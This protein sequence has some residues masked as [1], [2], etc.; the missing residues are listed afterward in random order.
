M[1]L[2]IKN[3]NNI[4]D[5]EVV[6]S[7][8]K[9]NI[10]FA[11]NGTGKSTIAKA[12]RI[13]IED[14][15][16]LGDLMPFK[17]RK[18]NPDN[19][20]PT[21]IGAEG[22]GSVLCFNEDYVNQF[23]FQKEEL[24]SNSFNVFFRNDEYVEGERK[25]E[26]LMTEIKSAFT[27]D[28]Q[29]EQLNSSLKEMGSAF[30][31]SKTGL[32]KASAGMKGLSKGNKLQHIPQGLEPYQPFLQSQN[33]VGWIDWQTK[34]CEFLE[35]DSSCPFCT[36][37][38]TDKHEVIKKIGNEYD[39]NSI[40]NLINLIRVI[41]EL[42]DFF[43][44]D[45]RSKLSIITTLQD[46]LEKEHEEY[47]VGI[48]KNIDT[49]VA[50]LERLKALSGF[51]FKDG[52][53]VSRKLPAYK[54]DLAFFPAL[55]SAATQA[56]ISPI[57][58]SIDL[59]IQKSG[60]LQGEINIQRQRMQSIIERNQTEINAF[61]VYA[62]YKYTVA[63]VGDGGEARLRL[64]HI[65]HEDFLNG[66]SQ[67]LSFGERNA[68]ALVLFMYEC[69]SKKP[70]LIVLDDPISSFDKN[71][72]YAILEMLFRRDSAVCLKNKTVL[73]LTHDIEPII[74]TVKALSSKFSNQTAASH[75]K[76]AGGIISDFEI[77]RDDIQTFGQICTNALCSDKHDLI[78]LIYLR[79]DLEISDDK[80]D[81]HEVISNLLHKRETLLDSRVRKQP[82]ED[83]PGMEPAKVENGCQ[84]IVDR[85]PQFDY[86]DKLQEISDKGLLRELYRQSQNGYEKLRLF[87]FLELDVNN[88]V[89]QKFINETYHIENE[90]ICQ[91]DPSKFDLLPEY[92]INECDRLI[93]ESEPA[94]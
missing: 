81:A 85:L 59:L 55:D 80:G 45:A 72:K 42:G 13:K 18:T 90:F 86:E 47:I 76:L 43:T 61:L 37:Q 93:R 10:K 91:L 48:K 35:L 67:H 49:L 17:L 58:D 52:E 23:V 12:I 71:K 63:I 50:K 28:Q 9:L 73:M 83:L 20:K 27:N 2:N 53:Q 89:I 11:P 84:A 14:D 5:A 64:L 88:S 4:D 92:V 77:R 39:K 69:L 79:R 7:E 41:D 40:K 29:L 31:L 24:L 74:D 46:G 8:G 94:A 16:S 38:A 65:D 21:V 62:G 57:N 75:L 68:F 51:D 44:D 15:S 82:D 26:E 32:S 1:N 60:S 87:R 19:K 25:I 22:L 3:C 56:A 30:K 6:I 34:G 78:K 36:S 70:D 54:L 33:S 66:G